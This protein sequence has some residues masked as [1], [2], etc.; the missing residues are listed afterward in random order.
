[1]LNV[2][3]RVVLSRAVPTDE[4]AVRFSALLD[5]LGQDMADQVRLNIV[6]FGKPGGDGGWPPV[7]GW[8]QGKPAVESA[9]AREHSAIAKGEGAEARR[10]ARA[11]K[12]SRA[13]AKKAS[14]AAR[15]ASKKAKR[16]SAAAKYHGRSQ[17][18]ANLRLEARAQ[19]AKAKA[20]RASAKEH[21]SSAKESSASSKAPR[22]AA[23]V[24]REQAAAHR[25]RARVWRA[26]GVSD[27]TAYARRKEEG[28]TPGR[29]RFRA[30]ELLRDTEALFASLAYQRS[31]RGQARVISLFADG[32]APG[33]SI[34]NQRLLE[35]H[36]LGEGD[37]PQ[38]D[39]TSDMANYEAR[40][41][42]RLDA[43]WDAVFMGKGQITAEH[44][45]GGSQSAP[46]K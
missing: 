21:R 39:P 12:A 27:H 23:K 43:F 31:E 38:R 20:L 29:G 30:D 10:A 5:D 46:R 36:A 13:E 24:S 37:M 18:A 9:M 28:K 15:L 6:R 16:A 33:R 26:L 25:E 40:V 11:A 32:T 42:R 17:A 3:T 1:M 8:K 19:R 34:T 41:Q 45:R 22:S 44:A 4:L 7:S 35:V 2:R 14:A